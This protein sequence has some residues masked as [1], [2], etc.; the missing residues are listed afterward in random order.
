MTTNLDK[1]TYAAAGVDI[2]KGDN[3][4]KKIKTY[5]DST[6]KVGVMSELGTFAS[7]FTMKSLNYKNPVLASSTD[8][9]GTK[10]F[11][12]QDFGLHYQAGLDLVAMSTNDVLCHGAQ[13][14][15]FLDYIAL[16]NN[17]DDDNL[18][19]F[20]RGVADGCNRA[21]CAL[22]GG[23]TAYLSKHMPDAKYEAAGFC[24][25][26]VEKVNLLPKK[27]QAGDYV[28][29]LLSS[30]L[31]CNGYSMLGDVVDFP[32]DIV[33]QV[34]APCKDYV[35]DIIDIV[36]FLSGIAN[37]TGGGLY[38]NVVRILPEKLHA[39]L[40]ITWKVPSVYTFIKSGKGT[41]NGLPVDR[42][43]MLRTFNCGI[44]MVLVVNP[45]H[46]ERIAE[47]LGD[48]KV[49]FHQIGVIR[50]T[51]KKGVSVAGILGEL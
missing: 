34:L 15:F 25:G 3:F 28:L 11:L 22:V 44:G 40:D 16:G 42:D 32:E 12:L 18:S 36:P 1:A 37:I 48:R 26:A 38:E 21:G 27:I 13:P 47:Y 31:H 20:I 7:L 30:G 24:V 39:F 29:G 35:K 50:E 23:E 14:L 46:V 43:E 33:Q 17:V 45:L 51:G 49:D 19:Q 4:V 41:F 6:Y 8:G 2:E 5:S 9:V 10:L